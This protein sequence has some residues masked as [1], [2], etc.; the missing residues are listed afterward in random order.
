MRYDN[1]EP[2]PYFRLRWGSRISVNDNIQIISKNRI[3]IDVIWYRLEG[4]GNK[5]DCSS[6]VFVRLQKTFRISDKNKQWSANKQD[7]MT[8]GNGKRERENEGRRIADRKNSTDRFSSFSDFLLFASTATIVA[9]TETSESPLPDLLF[10]SSL[11]FPC[12]SFF[13]FV[14]VVFSS[15]LIH[16]THTLTDKHRR[17]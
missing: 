6:L 14:V 15:S 11:S 2:C 8:T 17:L 10:S 3:A 12:V 4:R 9:I 5:I 1:E 13:F 7:K 16:I